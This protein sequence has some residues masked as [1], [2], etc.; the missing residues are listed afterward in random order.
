M[1]QDIPTVIDEN[2]L[3]MR[4]GGVAEKAR[5]G[6]PYDEDNDRLERILNR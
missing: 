6:S 1:A 2:E 3:A 5:L 4:D